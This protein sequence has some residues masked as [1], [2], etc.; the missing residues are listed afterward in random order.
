MPKWWSRHDRVGNGG[1]GAVA[2]ISSSPGGSPRASWM[3]DPIQSADEDLLG[4]GDFARHLARVVNGVGTFPSSTVVGLVGPWGSGKTSIINLMERDL[5]LMER[6]L[7]P[8]WGVSRFDPWE[9]SDVGALIQG[10]F[11]AISI[12]LPD[13]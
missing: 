7:E 3:D 1:P 9:S 5:K 13:D 6:D 11:R 8:T 10:F 4:R 2:T 12:A